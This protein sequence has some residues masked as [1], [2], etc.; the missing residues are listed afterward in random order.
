M[1]FFDKKTDVIKIELT[2]YGKRLLAKGKFKPAY[3]E[4]FDNDVLYDG[5]YASINEERNDIQNRIKNNT[6]YLK[7][8]YNFVG[9]ETRLK[10]LKELKKIDEKDINF[11]NLKTSEMTSF[12]SLEE[13]LSIT[14]YP[15]GTSKLNS[16]Y[17]TIKIVSAD[18]EISSSQKY[19]DLNG[20]ILHIPQIQLQNSEYIFQVIEVDENQNSF[21]VQQ[22]ESIL[23]KIEETNVKDLKSVKVNF[24]AVSQEEIAPS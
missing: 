5:N 4:F 22:E 13:K 24:I 2:P 14:S 23:L 3:Y 6:S 7:P 9:A 8:Q 21:E 18:T 10:N 17:P 15:L 20:F 1:S 16:E 12:Q 19:T 11:Q